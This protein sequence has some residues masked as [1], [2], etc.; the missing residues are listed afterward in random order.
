MF[1]DEATIFVQGGSGG[2]G[3]VAF[4]REKFVPDGGPAGGDGGRGGDVIFQVD[5]GLNTL[6][7]FRH[8]RHFRAQ[9][10]EP[11]GTN[12]RHGRDGEDLVIKVPPGTVVRH[13]NGEVICDLVHVHDSAVIAQGGRGGKGNVHFMSSTH[14]APKV[15]ERGEPG[16]AFWVRV[17]LNLL[18]DVGLV[19]FP[20]AGKSTL[21]SVVSAARPKIADY[22]FTTLVPNL[23]VVADYGAPFVIADV[24]GL[25]EGAHTGTGLGDLFLRH[26]NRTRLLLHLVDLSPTSGRDPVSDYH[27]IR[28]ELQSFSPELAHKPTIVVGTKRDVPDSQERLDRLNRALQPDSAWGISAVTGLAISDL[29]WAV[30]R[31]LDEI[32]VAAATVHEV[33]EHPLVR[34]Y[35]VIADAHGGVRLV[36]DIEQRASMTL[37]GN[38][39]AENYFC[40][41]LRRRGVVQALLRAGVPD[42]VPVRVGDGLLFFRDG[43]LTAEEPD[44]V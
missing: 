31:R 11:G 17:E 7:D 24:P 14:R 23:G 4:R 32:P 33:A 9:S 20:N 39:H 6:M 44:E 40:E 41:Y 16:Q 2:N 3:S 21:I 22:P 8:Q 34:G 28:A 38:P 42:P 19:G 35:R 10:G 5:A 12:R 36:G 18:A 29:M 15:A 30:R 1:V 37:W 27:V 26:L 43:D 13:D 25:I